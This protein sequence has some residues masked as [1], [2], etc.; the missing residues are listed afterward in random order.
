M[1]A[2]SSPEPGTTRVFTLFSSRVNRVPHRGSDCRLD[3]LADA[4]R[5]GVWQG[6]IDPVRALAP[7]KREP[8]ES[9]KKKGPRAEQYTHLKENTL[10]YA[11]VSGTWQMDHRH[12]DHAICRGNPC[13]VN[14][15]VTP[16]GLRLL[17]LD[18]LNEAAQGVILQQLDA[19]AVPWA[20]SCWKSPGGDGLHLFALLDPAP[21]CQKD[22]HSAFAALVAD[23]AHRIPDASVASDRAAKNLMR[24]SYISSDPNARYYAE[25][26]PFDWRPTE[27][28]AAPTPPHDPFA[29][30]PPVEPTP[31]FSHS[32]PHDAQSHLLQVRAVAQELLSQDLAY[33]DWL[34]VMAALKASGLNA[35]EVEVLDAHNPLHKPGKITSKWEGLPVNDHPART[36]NSI[37]KRL[38]AAG[39]VRSPRTKASSDYTSRD[40]NQHSAPE[41]AADYV[42]LV[43]EHYPNRVASI[44]DD[45]ALRTDAGLWRIY[46]HGNRRDRGLLTRLIRTAR[47]AAG[48]IGKRVGDSTINNIVNDLHD[49]AAGRDLP[50]LHRTHL[51]RTPIVPFTDGTHLHLDYGRPETCACSLDEHP[52]L[53]FGWQIPP[54]DWSLF[55]HDRPDLLDQFDEGII[56]QIAERLH[57]PD[58]R[59]DFLSSRA[60]NGGKSSCTAACAACLPGI[61]DRIEASELNKDNIHFS[62]HS[63]PLAHCRILFLDEFT[64][65][66]MDVTPMLYGLTDDTVNINE[67]HAQQIHQPRLGTAIFVGDDEPTYNSVAQGVPTRIGL[68]WRPDI[69]PLSVDLARRELWL[70]DHQLAT[71]R[72]WLLGLALQGRRN[73]DVYNNNENRRRSM[74]QSV[75]QAILKAREAFEDWD[76]AVG[77]TYDAIRQALS[78]SQAIDALANDN[79]VVRMIS[80]AWPDAQKRQ[81]RQP[82][83][84]RPMLWYGINSSFDVS[85]CA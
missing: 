74:Q 13:P 6:L 9:G 81:C 71:L 15:I 85:T 62:V 32:S 45:I 75:P 78:N 42:D 22:S 44:G 46:D 1:S 68:V 59:A 27:S 67:K 12:A 34:G 7:Y 38:N 20:A 49:H 50:I 36:L 5:N 30:E 84:K 51:C 2:V 80:E 60:T 66:E 28:D 21:A 3:Q 69:K 64:K 83:G 65:N 53:D 17:D 48:D 25:A 52:W 73:P 61:I 19:G 39:R 63:A 72:A 41:T 70:S 8:D 82:D 26:R 57:G 33:N 56:T 43:M 76:P 35:S 79:Q 24:P 31:P 4:V 40:T 77:Y 47:L 14:G 29:P 11:V 54:P 23:L 18:D 37:S 55:D 16:S 58:K 10:P